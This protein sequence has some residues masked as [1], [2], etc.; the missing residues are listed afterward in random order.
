[1]PL[2]W[3]LPLLWSLRLLSLCTLPHGRRP[4]H[5]TGSRGAWPPAGLIIPGRPAKALG[6][7]PW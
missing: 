6:Y 4:W 7:E 1:L 5:R 2:L 3:P